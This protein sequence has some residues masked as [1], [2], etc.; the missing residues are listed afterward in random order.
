MDIYLEILILGNWELKT[1]PGELFSKIT[2]EPFNPITHLLKLPWAFPGNENTINNT[3]NS[4]SNQP[5]QN[6]VIKTQEP[7]KSHK[8][9]DDSLLKDNNFEDKKQIDNNVS[10]KSNKQIVKNYNPI[11]CESDS[12]K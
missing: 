4:I 1:S 6:E 12:N 9:Q 5:V 10:I 8:K 2:T 11:T 3:Y 7:K